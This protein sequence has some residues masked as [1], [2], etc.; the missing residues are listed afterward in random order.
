MPN[1]AYSFLNLFLRFR[2]ASNG[3]WVIRRHSHLPKALY[4]GRHIVTMLPGSG[5]GPELMCAVKHVFM[6]GG[7]PVNF[8]EIETTSDIDCEESLNHAITSIRR[9]G[10]GIKG[11]I[12]ACQVIQDVVSRNVV[13]RNQLDL[14]VN[15][16]NCKAYPS[17]P[18]RHKD[19]DLILIRHNTEGEY[20]MIEHESVKGLVESMRITTRMN[21]ERVA[22]FCFEY[23][24]NRCRKK[25][26]SIHNKKIMT[27]SDGLFL[28]TSSEVAKEYPEIEHTDMSLNEFCMKVVTNP[29][30]FDVLLLPNLYGNIVSHVVC[31]MIRGAGLISGENYGD[32]YAVFET[33]T[34]NAG[35][36]IAGKNIANPVSMLNA[37]V[38]MLKYLGYYF[39]ADIIKTAIH[40]T[41]N[42]D[43]IHTPDLG[44]KATSS[45]VLGNIISYVY[46]ARMAANWPYPKPHGVKGERYSIPH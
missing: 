1:Y 14:Y 6:C 40:K 38:D 45:D 44:G 19:L 21:S 9:N 33:G 42:E 20:S 41:I 25:V 35:T 18:S 12:E 23:A 28:S 30:Q 34:R 43:C 8:E 16:L 4:G 7:V 32:H 26:T 37:S 17:V 22:R 13:V 24:K 31:G 36:Q 10:V 15:V 11:N 29:Q 27:V 39:H 3:I 46:E 2:S 5:I